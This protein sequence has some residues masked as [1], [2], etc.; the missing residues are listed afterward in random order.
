MNRKDANTRFGLPGC[1]T[2][3]RWY[4]FDLN[5]PGSGIDAHEESVDL[6]VFDYQG[7]ASQSAAET[8]HQYSFLAMVSI[9]RLIHHIFKEL[10]DCK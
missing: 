7:A 9:R 5:L 6:P 4:Y 3:S 2:T 1:L 10:H 8:T